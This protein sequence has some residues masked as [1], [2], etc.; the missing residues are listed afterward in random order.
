ML[1]KTRTV[2][3]F[4]SPQEKLLFL[5]YLKHGDMVL[6]GRKLVLV[7]FSV[8]KLLTRSVVVLGLDKQYLHQQKTW[9]LLMY[10]LAETIPIALA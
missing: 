9:N 3:C 5:P 8:D 4:W 10:K 2:V 1:H 7:L 6:C